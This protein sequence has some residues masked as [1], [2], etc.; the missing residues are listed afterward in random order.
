MKLTF[1]VKSRQAASAF[2]GRKG[3]PGRWTHRYGRWAVL[4]GLIAAT[5]LLVSPF[6]FQ[7]KVRY[8]EGEV[9]PQPI[10]SEIPFT[11]DDPEKLELWQRRRDAN[12]TRVYRYD[13]RIESQARDRLQ[14]LFAELRK[15]QLT[16][17]DL[18][19]TRGLARLAPALEK[20]ATPDGAMGMV[21]GDSTLRTLWKRRH[22]PKY[23]RDL[24]EILWHL[25]ERGIVSSAAQY[26]SHQGRLRLD[27]AAAPPTRAFLPQ[28]L[29]DYP[30]GV[31]EYLTLYLRGFFEG[32]TERPDDSP[33]AAAREVLLS[34]V[35][36]N[37][38]FDEAASLLQRELYKVGFE[39]VRRTL[40]PG[41]LLLAAG[42]TVTDREKEMLDAYN[43]ALRH[44][45][46][47][48]LLGN[49]G[50]VLLVFAIMGFYILKIRREF[51]FDIHTLL[52]TGLPLVLVL[53]IE[54][55]LLIVT[56]S[57]T[58]MDLAGYAFPA[59]TIGML[60][61]LL[62]D[63]RMAL[64]LVT[65]GCLLFGL[66]VNLDFR[67]VAVALLGGYTAVAALYTMRERR[68]V[69]LAGL[70]IGLVNAAAILT[71][72]FIENPLEIQWRLAVVG[73]IGGIVCSL[74][75]IAVMPV[76]EVLFG[77]VT[78][79]RLLELTGLHHPL[80]VRLEQ[81][82][83]GTWEHTLSVAKLAEAA[84]QAIGLNYLLVR[85]GAYF[86]DV[87]KMRKPPYFTENQATPEDKRRHQELRPQMSVLI[88]RDHVKSGVEL[89]RQAGLPE[90]IVEFIPQHHGTSLIRYFYLKALKH[91]ESGETKA[92]VREE[93][94]R[95]PGPKPQSRETA[96][97]MLADA[98][99]AT[100]TAKLTA[101]HVREDDIQRIVRDTVL[102]KFNDGQF[103]ECDLTLRDLQIIRESFVAQLLSRYHTRIDYPKMPEKRDAAPAPTAPL[104]PAPPQ[105]ESK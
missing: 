30:E 26:R 65:W 99:E 94:Y 14:A 86:H 59:G 50:F 69:I 89:A 102:E 22:D 96:I 15:F 32:T 54:R 78:D 7:E 5:V 20:I 73:A 80:R 25:F 74:L 33:R 13:S 68:E 83:P 3:S 98:V 2:L 16:P 17:E 70:R 28:Q 84:A 105:R 39:E 64:I 88:I 67:Y 87:G 60:G 85:A 8:R 49:I 12:Y 71:I 45:F 37:I 44:Y 29:L 57:R 43:S 40:Q 72:N 31:R 101:A 82:A 104:A 35:L 47:R 79:M 38:D 6:F 24:Q 103:D 41:D 81:E 36:P 90:K 27:W 91:F 18:E 42:Y 58:S 75:T 55:M 1:L 92:P 21:L 62:L 63:V 95:Y 11:Y 23:F 93:D 51:A 34:L 4:L 97:V 48:R 9:A 100:A 66:E 46:G 61:V 77:V 10:Y 76:L 52:L 56:E 53:A 19:S